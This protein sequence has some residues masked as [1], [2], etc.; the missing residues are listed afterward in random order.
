VPTRLA[1]VI[2]NDPG[3]R[4]RDASANPDPGG[5]PHP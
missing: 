4:R 2:G 3:W 5:S 1:R